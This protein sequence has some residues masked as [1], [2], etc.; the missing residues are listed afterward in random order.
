MMANA[1]RL[2]SNASPPPRQQHQDQDMYHKSSVPE[3][4]WTL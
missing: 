2:P 4:L 1:D 3:D